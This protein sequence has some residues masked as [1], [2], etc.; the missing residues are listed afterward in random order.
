MI[1]QATGRIFISLYPKKL[2]QEPSWIALISFEI[3]ENSGEKIILQMKVLLLQPWYVVLHI[4]T[5]HW[6]RQPGSNQIKMTLDIL[7]QG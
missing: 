3:D 2:V 7:S 1:V 4:R 5:V 6:R